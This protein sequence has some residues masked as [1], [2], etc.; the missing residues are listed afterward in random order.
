[1]ASV[2]SAGLAW[3]AILAVLA[4]GC[5]TPRTPLAHG[6]VA[7]GFE[8]VKAEFERNFVERGERGAAVAVYVAG[9]KVVDL[10]GGERNDG[11]APWEESTLVPVYSTTKGVAAL[12]I[13]I[14]ASQGWLDYDAPVAR[15]WPEF[16][17]KGK[18]AITVRQL[19]SHEAGLVLLD[20]EIPYETVRD[21]DAL[22]VV[23]ARQEPSWTPGTRH[24]YHLS[25]LGF[26]MNELF[27]RV[28]PSHRSIGRYLREVIAPALG[29]E[30]YIGAPEHV[31][32]DRVAQ[33]YVT[34]PLGGLAHLGDPPFAVLT[35][36]LSPWSTMT[37]TF[38]IP[39]GYDVNDPRWWRVEMPSGNGITTARAL[40]RLYSTFAT[41]S[42]TA[43]TKLSVELGLRPDV[44]HALE[45]PPHEPTLGPRDEVLG[46]DSYYGLGFIKP[47]PR[48]TW[49]TSP[50]AYGM[51]G[52]GGSFAFADPDRQVAFAYV[53]NKM[54]YFMSDDPREK[55]LRDA[56]YRALAARKPPRIASR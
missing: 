33:V 7:P 16:A 11:H 26:Y 20:E 54:G 47:A 3:T 44:L 31:A 13:A 14:A 19:V 1:M 4:L 23:L 12:V 49:G 40:A 53:M 50:R 37:R 34:S 41:A 6:V 55:A 30:I 48:P 25:T 32:K 42:A 21:L 8:G 9:E 27:R 45:G 5:G 56:T 2:S 52:A 29:I 24:G 22:A 39:E 36:L 17:S 46:V 15:Y 38:A 18:A 51:S 43:S 35:R 28:E 10:W